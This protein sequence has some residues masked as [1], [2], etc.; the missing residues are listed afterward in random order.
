MAVDETRHHHAPI[1][2]N[3]FGVPAFQGPDLPIGPYFLNK[4]ALYSQSFGH[5]LTRHTRPNLPSEEDHV[6]G[7]LRRGTG[8]DGESCK[9]LGHKQAMSGNTHQIILFVR[10]FLL[11]T[12]SF[13]HRWKVILL[14]SI[15]SSRKK[16]S[17]SPPKTPR[18]RES[19]ENSNPSSVFWTPD[20]GT[21][22][23]TP[24]ET[25]ACREVF[26]IV[27]QI[28]DRHDSCNGFSVTKGRLHPEP[29]RYHSHFPR[30]PV[31]S[32]H[33]DRR[34]PFGPATPERGRRRGKA[35][36]SGR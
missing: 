32:G 21:P 4:S 36:G 27:N 33:S 22:R 30:E 24:L 17:K 16:G 11:R 23:P 28:N 14:L 34:T 15:E 1:Q 6:G 18:F 31:G 29:R 2:P 25:Q 13:E 8:N 35:A 12:S 19:E 3:H 20:Y 10:I 9:R 26:R 5:G 7:D